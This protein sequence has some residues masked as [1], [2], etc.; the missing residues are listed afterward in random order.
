MEFYAFVF[1]FFMKTKCKFLAEEI[2][3][4]IILHTSHYNAFRS[5]AFPIKEAEGKGLKIITPKQMLQKLPKA[6]AQA[7]LKNWMK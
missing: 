3:I 6:F 7:H 1:T 5:G 2:K 4:Y